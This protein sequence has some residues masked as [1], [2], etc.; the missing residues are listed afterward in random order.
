MRNLNKTF[1]YILL[2]ILSVNFTSAVGSLGMDPRQI[3][4]ASIVVFF[5]GD[6]TTAGLT[7]ATGTFI[8]S[9]KPGVATYRMTSSQYGTNTTGF[10]SRI[11][12]NQY[13]VFFRMSLP[14]AITID[15]PR[16]YTIEEVGNNRNGI[17]YNKPTSNSWGSRTRTS[18][19]EYD[20]L[21]GL[22]FTTG[23]E[24]DIGIT[25][26][27]THTLSYINGTLRN[28]TAHTG[29]LTVGNNGFLF[30]G[31]GTNCPAQNCFDHTIRDYTI[32]NRSLTANEF[33][34][35][36]FYNSSTP[37]APTNISINQSTYNLTSAIN[38]GNATIWRTNTSYPAVTYDLT[39]TIKFNVSQAAN[40]TI[41]LNDY[42]YTRNVA[43]PGTYY[44]C[45]EVDSISQTCTYG[46][47]LS[48]ATQN[49]FLAC[50][51]SL[52]L[53]STSGALTLSVQVLP[54]NITSAVFRNSTY[55]ASINDLKINW[56][57]VN[58]THYNVTSGNV[59]WTLRQENVTYGLPWLI[60][61]TNRDTVN[62]SI[63]MNL[64]RYVPS[65]AVFRCNG[66]TIT[67]TP[68]F[69]FNMTPNT[70]VRINCTANVNLSMSLVNWTVTSNNANWSTNFTIS[71]S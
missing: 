71:A 9:D 37:P 15:Y 69:L 63:Y 58:Y 31:S 68:T 7:D 14:T 56:S 1:V 12:G 60:N 26:N 51:N 62:A 21:W 45:S 25:W 29:T 41:S 40:C 19:G 27:G 34:N 61:I 38:S 49:I 22:N 46:T 64:T 48:Y 54:I 17:I 18:T 43:G 55:N 13:S 28:A 8:A 39:P 3:D 5:S 52:N 23:V 47:A 59:N 57:R 4:N 50:Q 10:A 70:T 16:M 11:T 30:Q 35:L 24:V 67:D 20:T 53:N 44:N 36:S 33:Y 66:T 42:N 32:W 65:I 2:I 6:N